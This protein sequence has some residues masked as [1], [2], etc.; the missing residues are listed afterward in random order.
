VEYRGG[1][2]AEFITGSDIWRHRAAAKMDGVTSA[3]RI[4]DNEGTLVL[5]RAVLIY[6]EETQVEKRPWQ[7]ETLFAWSVPEKEAVEEADTLPVPGCLASRKT[8]RTLRQE[9]RRTDV[10]L[11]LVGYKPQI[12]TDPAHLDRAG[13]KELEHIDLQDLYQLYCWGN[14]Q[15]SRKGMSLT[16]SS[17]PEGLLPDSLFLKH[18]AMVPEPLAKDEEE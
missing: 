8:Q 7:F 1:A 13:K 10:S 12:C 3:F 4:A 9:I 11:E 14:R 15:L 2:K 18:L 17:Y 6:D 16:A 5:E